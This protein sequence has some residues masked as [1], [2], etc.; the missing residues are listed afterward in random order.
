[1]TFTSFNSFANWC[2]D[3]EEIKVEEY[4]QYEEKLIIGN[5]KDTNGMLVCELLVAAYD[6]GF[7]F[8]PMMENFY[9]G[10]IVFYQ[11]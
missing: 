9:N 11:D 4:N 5:L 6:S 10:C 2:K 3:V 1:M 7:T 8:G